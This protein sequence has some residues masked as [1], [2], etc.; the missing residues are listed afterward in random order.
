LETIGNT[1]V[2][3]T[4]LTAIGGSGQSDRLAGRVEVLGSGQVALVASLVQGSEV[5]IGGDFQGRG[6]LITA[7]ETIVDA[8]S[9]INASGVPLNASGLS[10]LPDS[11]LPP[12][13]LAGRVIV[14]ADDKTRFLGRLRNAAGFAEIS[15]KKELDLGTDWDQRIQVGELLLDPNNITIQA[16]TAGAIGSSPTGTTPL[17]ATTISN[18]L[19]NNGDLII[20]TSLGTGGAGDITLNAGAA[21]SWTSDNDLT[22]TA[23]RSIILNAGSSI[24]GTSGDINLNANLSGAVTSGSQGILLNGGDLSTTSGTINLKGIGGSA[25][26]GGGSGNH[27]IA[28]RNGSLVTTVTGDINYNGRSGVAS[29]ADNDGIRIFEVRELRTNKLPVRRDNCNIP[30]GQCFRA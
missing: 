23:D 29:V 24:S 16:G 1:T 15:G 7:R 3:N 17:G 30:F 13:A 19:Q 2:S 18:F 21:I 20:T 4:E 5:Y 25:G 11:P 26:T 28:Q 14:W 8:A 6:E 22:L 12:L 10:G 9:T 27:G